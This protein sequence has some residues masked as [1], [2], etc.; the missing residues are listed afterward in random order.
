MIQ[1]CTNPEN[2]SFARY[3]GRGITVCAR[4][5]GSF[6][7]FVEDMGPRPAGGTIDRVDVD[8]NYEPAN[9]RWASR[10]VQAR[11]ILGERHWAAKLSND[12]VFAIARQ[13]EIGV[14]SQTQLAQW[15]GVSP[16]T[17]TDIRKGR[18]QTRGSGGTDAAV[19][20]EARPPKSAITHCPQGH[21]YDEINTYLYRGSRRCRKCVKAAVR[22][23]KAR[24]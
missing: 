2:K 1:R 18:T 10:M 16:S 12:S 4:W 15:F 19:V 22:R 23:H 24:S 8:G 13:L 17:I 21:P 5:L 3:G 14:F 20:A 7:A 6:A 11:D 9:C